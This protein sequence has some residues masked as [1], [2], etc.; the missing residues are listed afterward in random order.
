MKKISFVNFNPRGIKPL[1]DEF[2][3]H[4]LPVADVAA[5]NIPKRED[6]FQIKTATLTFESG[7]KL[8][9]KI[10][11]NGSIFQVR[12]NGKV[13]PVKNSEDLHEPKNLKKAVKEMADFVGKNEAGYT[14]Q[15]ERR[16][17]KTTGTAPKRASTSVAKQ[18]TF[19]KALSQDLR[20]ENIELEQGL[21]EKKQ[22]VDSRQTTI[23]TLKAELETEQNRNDELKVE[24]N[25]LLEAE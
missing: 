18:L 8:M 24:I 10:K 4:K 15:K 12:L 25:S 6:G 2:K 13:V 9:V 23:G 14:K 1:S 5:T 16:M 19:N 11:A 7:Q 22:S 3:K 20:E 17:G 21:A